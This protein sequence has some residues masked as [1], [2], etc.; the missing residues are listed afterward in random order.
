MRISKV[1]PQADCNTRTQTSPQATHPAPH[2][3]SVNTITSGPSLPAQLPWTM[4]CAPSPTKPPHR[5]A[6]NKLQ[7]R[8]ATKQNKKNM[9][10]RY[11]YDNKLRTKRKA[12]ADSS[13]STRSFKTPQP[14]NAGDYQT[15][16]AT[17]NK[18]LL[19]QITNNT[20]AGDTV[21][22]NSLPHHTFLE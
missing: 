15:P 5:G 17:A 19:P 7:T 6:M 8:P 3:P 2:P 1:R 22:K 14:P 4:K 13:H 21:H 18:H 10:H 12:D 16:Y 20:H 9:D 11:E